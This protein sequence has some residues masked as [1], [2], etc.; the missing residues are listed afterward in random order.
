MAQ[1]C[2]FCKIIAG[3]IPATVVYEDDDVVAFKDISPQAPVHVLIVPRAH[4]ERLSDATEA[5]ASL[6]G[7]IVLAGNRVARLSGVAKSGYR[8]IANTGPDGGQEVF[9]VHFH[10]LGGKRLGRMVS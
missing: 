2:L 6:L 3:E 4:I 7:K 5:D 10:V 1:D 9:H 8:L